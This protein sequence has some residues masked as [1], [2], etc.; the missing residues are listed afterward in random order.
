MKRF[1]EQYPLAVSLLLSSGISVGLFLV[2]AW[3]Y[4]LGGYWFLIWNLFLAWLPLGFAIWLKHYLK[5][6]TWLS[7]QAV[8]LSLLWLGFLPNSF[9]MVTDLIHL[10]TDF[11]N[12]SLFAAVMMFSFAINGV[13]LGFISL[14]MI[15]RLLLARSTRPQAHYTIAAVL[16]LSSFAIYLG[17]YL[18][19]STWDVL[20]NPAG[21][22][23]DVSDRVFINPTSHPQMFVTTAIFFVLL[24]SIYIV[25]WQAIWYIKTIKD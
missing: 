10:Q 14:F 12:T 11:I 16:L 21:L 9:Y 6:N 17:R 7:W 5:K 19:W 25:L 15:H 22:L 1:W 3:R 13:I 4:D 8:I 23:F 24:C 20:V 2:G 18:R